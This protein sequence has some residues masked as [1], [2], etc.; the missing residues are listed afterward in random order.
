M[1]THGADAARLRTIAEQ[2]RAQ[3]RRATAAEDAGTAQAARLQDAWEGEDLETFTERWRHARVAIARCAERL[4]AMATL[5]LEQA[6]QQDAASEEA[7]AGG[8]SGG[9]AGPGR[10]TSSGPRAPGPEDGEGS[11]FDEDI[12]GTEGQPV[13]KDLWQLAFHAQGTEHP[14]HGVPIIGYDLPP[15]PEGYEQVTPDEIAEL[16]LDPA[17]FGPDA[18]PQ[19]SIYRTPDGGYVVAFQGSV[20]GGD[21]LT[22]GRQ[23]LTGDDPQFTA[24]ME[25]AAQVDAATGGDVTFTGHS[26]GGGLAA[27]AALATGQPAVTF[28]ASGIHPETAEQA[29]QILGDGSTGAE[30]LAGASEGQIRAYALETDILT[31]VQTSTGLPDAA[32]TQI[33]L[34]TPTSPERDIV[35]TAGA[36]GGAAVGIVTGLADGDLFDVAEDAATGAQVGR[37]VADG[38]WGHSWDPMTEAMEERYP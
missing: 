38:V 3:A 33:T 6:D 19:A 27:A 17:S 37:D 11:S 23:A 12:R 30:L 5:M 10:R 26:L 2:L 32:G 29:A 8:R 7:G 34:D 36:A 9:E 24:A 20:E 13:D 14:L 15:L 16:G 22:N 35:T 25:L 31:D 28:D 18:Q 4:D 1:L 21:W